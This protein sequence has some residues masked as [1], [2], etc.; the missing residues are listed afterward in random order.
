M[1]RKRKTKK[2][3]EHLKKEDVTAAL[4]KMGKGRMMERMRLQHQDSGK[5]AKS[6][7][8]MAR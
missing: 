2:L 1:L 4:E 3:K 5:R 6:V 8:G 7:T